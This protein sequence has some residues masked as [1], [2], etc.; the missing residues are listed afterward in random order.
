MTEEK[1]SF[2]KRRT[3]GQIRKLKA[4]LAYNG[5]NLLKK[6]E[7]SD[8]CNDYVEL[9]FQLIPGKFFI[10][11][12][13]SE[14]AARKSLKY[15]ELIRLSHPESR[16]GCYDSSEIPLAMRE[17]DFSKLKGMKEEEIRV[18]GYSFQPRWGGDNL[19]RVVPFVFCPEGVRLF[20]YSETMKIPG[21]DRRGIE[22]V[23]ENYDDAERVRR[24]GAS[25]V[26]EVPSRTRKKPRYKLKLLHV[27]TT[28]G[29][30]NLASV[31]TLKN[32]A[33][34]DDQGEPVGNS[35]TP[36]AVYNIRYTW[37]SENERSEVI[38]FYPQDIAS[39][40]KIAGECWKEHNLT[41]MEM[42]PFALFSQR[43]VDI[44]KKLENNVLI[45]DPTISSKSGRGGLRRL[46]LCEVSMLLARAIGVFG[47]NEIAYW[48]PVRDGKLKDYD[49]KV[50]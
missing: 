40:I 43:G 17:R 23:V 42:N 24:E 9:R 44:Y 2:F 22:I 41:P 27:P 28:R 49:W 33:V 1:K 11:S 14:E 47:H 18:V 20:A 29:K 5:R 30:E 45:F 38:T 19:K 37:D 15:G 8:S 32:S 4:V 46:R 31:L 34:I 35:Q 7:D 39:Y 50:R 26:C 13:T 16:Q 25:V 6:I 10:N 36:H 21:T 3:S 12:G 48:D